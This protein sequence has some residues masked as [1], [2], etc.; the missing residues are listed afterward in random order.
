MISFGSTG[1]E[2]QLVPYVNRFHGRWASSNDCRIQMTIAVKPQVVALHRIALEHSNAHLSTVHHL[3]KCVLLT[4][5]SGS[6][7]HRLLPLARS[8]IKLLKNLLPHGNKREKEF[9]LSGWKKSST[10]GWY[11]ML[12]N[13]HRI[14]NKEQQ[15]TPIP[16]HIIC[17]HIITCSNNDWCKRSTCS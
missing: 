9:E 2:Y 16:C 1:W 4:D 11:E 8:S 5:L 12:S 6:L 13:A 17:R 3:E 15:Y 14:G 7:L 10:N